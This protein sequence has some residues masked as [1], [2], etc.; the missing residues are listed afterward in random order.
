MK[1]ITDKKI[2]VVY[3]VTT[4]QANV[5]RIINHELVESKVEFEFYG[6][7]KRRYIVSELRRLGYKKYVFDDSDITYSRRIAEVPYHDL[8]IL[9]ERSIS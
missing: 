3:W 4:V 2:Q 8:D 9:S 6:R 1:I 7:M 5:S